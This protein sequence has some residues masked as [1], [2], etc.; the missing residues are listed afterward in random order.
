M[1]S[2]SINVCLVAGP[3][4]FPV[5]AQ[6]NDAGSCMYRGHLAMDID[7]LQTVLFF[8]YFT[9]LIVRGKSISMTMKNMK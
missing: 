5:K 4:L 8:C 2:D 6:V 3:V 9:W 1:T 7:C